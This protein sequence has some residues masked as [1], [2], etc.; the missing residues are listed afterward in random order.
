MRVFSWII[1]V[2]L[3]VSCET[4]PK[5][6]VTIKGKV[7]SS[8]ISSFKVASRGFSRT[9]DVDENGMFQ[10]TMKVEPGFFVFLN[11]QKDGLNIFLENGND[12]EILFND[13]RFSSG[14]TFK[15]VGSES[16]NYLE[17]KRAY[18]ASDEAAPDSFFALSR[19]EF[20]SKIQDTKNSFEAMRSEMKVHPMVMEIDLEN[21]KMYFEFLKNNYEGMHE[22]AA[23]LAPGSLSPK[24]V[25]YEDHKG[26]TKSLDDFKGKYVYLDIW[27]TWCAPC[28]AEIPFLKELEKDFHG[29]NIEFISISVDKEHAYDKWRTMVEEESL[30]GVQL[31]ADK[32]FESEFILE[33]GIRAIPRFI[34]ID[35]DGNIVN[36]NA[37]RPSDPKIRDYFQELGI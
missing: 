35:P 29:K 30:T 26:G 13:A 3:V 16:N 18:Y 23:K 31:M 37:K 19:P 11:G 5:D 17:K 6:Y 9:I 7:N 1:V 20:D 32:N 15:G 27:A 28:K 12:L 8:E 10:D 22:L 33:Y 25:N 14:A 21:E 4:K 24:F 2:L 34:L 36:S